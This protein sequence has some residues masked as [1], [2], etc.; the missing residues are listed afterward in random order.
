MT[1]AGRVG[2]RRVLDD[3]TAVTS[4]RPEL[5]WQRSGDVNNVVFVQ[6]AIP[7]PDGTIYLTVGAA[8]TASARPAS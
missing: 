4:A 7:R 3:R 6:G 5:P 8:T 1:V 2:D